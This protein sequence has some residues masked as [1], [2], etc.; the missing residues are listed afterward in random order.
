MKKRDKIRPWRRQFFEAKEKVIMD[1]ERPA[2]VFP[3]AKHGIKLKEKRNANTHSRK[4][5]RR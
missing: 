5:N 3:L 4:G 1:E 2:Q